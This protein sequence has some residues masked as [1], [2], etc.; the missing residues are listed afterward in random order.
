M[1]YD[2]VIRNGFV[3]DGSGLGAYRADVGVVDDR[4]AAVG[5]I[6]DRG[7]VEIDA[8]GHVVTPGFIDVHTHFDAQ[9]FWDR[10]GT[11]SCWH[12]VT[13]VVMG[14]CGFTLAPAAAEEAALVVRNLERAEDISAV[15]LAEGI[16]WSWTTFPEFLDTVDRLPKGINYAALF[17][18]SAVRTHVMGQRAFEEVATDD[19]LR[20]MEA[21]LREGMAA[22]A[23]GFSTS[24]TM[25]H[26]TSDD[27]PVASRLAA[28]SEVDH[29]VRVVAGAGGGNFQFVEDPL[30]GEEAA[31]RRDQLIALAVDTG[32]TFTMAVMKRP[33]LAQLDHATAAGARFVGVC[34]PRG[35]GAMSSFRTQLPFDRLPVWRDFR[36]LPLD[37]Q[38]RRLHDD[39][40]VAEL[41]RAAN[42]SAYGEAVG[43]EARPPEFDRM[44]VM[45]A[46]MPPNPTVAELARAR[47]VDPVECMIQLARETDL[48]QFFV[49]T[50]YPFDVDEA[51]EVL[52][53]PQVVMGF[54]DSGAHVSQM[55][56]AS[57]QTHLLGHYVRDRGAFSL[58][59]A[60]RMM[61]L[62][63][64][65]AYGFHDRGMVREGLVAD[66]NVFDPA[67]VAPAMPT[68]VHDLPGGETRI[69][70]T[71]EGIAATLV[72][73][74]V[75]VRDGAHTGDFPGELIRRR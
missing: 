57:I 51:V 28:W 29:L 48:D 72:R 13:T 25:Q 64:A 65:R 23:A 35:I 26:R 49:Q 30:Q 10:A 21:H 71:A 61:T 40:V 63:P 32:V 31:A 41:V 5:R 70:Q 14:N 33:A 60:V 42:E 15:A 4:I 45:D 39:T 62:A 46:P 20:A 59:E 75:T 69:A 2:V 9:I 34:H 50:F 54:S 22:G 3:V 1:A 58:E 24:R 37:E 8:D 56:D 74:R 11:N 19:D 67:T 53:H 55:S 17:G 68:V 16:D 43:A 38:L 66:L 6:T 18:H 52:R 44:R 73:G 12:G 27:K 36:S 7:T 47:D